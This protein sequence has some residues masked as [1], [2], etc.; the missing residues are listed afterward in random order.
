MS[1]F[2]LNH[3]GIE[4][5]IENHATKEA[6]VKK[7]SCVYVYFWNQSRDIDGI[8]K[9][10]IRRYTFYPLHHYRYQYKSSLSNILKKNKQYFSNKY[11]SRV[12]CSQQVVL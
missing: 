3:N 11:Q 7:I 12:D 6:D 4:S 10:H 2:F 9:L 5:Y 8:R 1:L